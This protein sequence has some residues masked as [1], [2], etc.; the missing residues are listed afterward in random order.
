M[1]NQT[2]EYMR[3]CCNFNPSWMD[4]KLDL[5]KH[6]PEWADEVP[7]QIK[8]MAVKEA[9][10]AFWKAKGRPQWRSLKEPEQTCYIIKSA[11]KPSKGIYPQKSGK[12]LK[13]N[14]S[15]PDNIK[16]GRLIWRFAKWWLA[17]PYKQKLRVAENQGRV[18][19]IDPGVRSFITFYN[20]KVAGHLGKGDFGRIQR[21]CVHMDQLISKRDKCSNKQRKRSMARAL[22]RMRGKLSHLIN[23]LHHKAAK[24]LTDNFD[25]ILL[26]TFETQSMSQRAGRKIS[27]KTVR[28]MLTF[29]HYRFK[30]FLKWKAHCTGKMVVDCS[31]AYTSKTHPETG[32]VRNI[33]GAS[34]IKLRDG[35]I[36]DRDI[37]GAR[38][39]MLRA[40]VDSPMGLEFCTAPCS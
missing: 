3:T 4:I 21:L 25:V 40:L 36:A 14:E 39:I 30:Q 31:E 12:G 38:N 29:A 11:V 7:Y 16:D 9:H 6:L 26:P 19:S 34:E 32:V 27:S 22:K 8:G 18:V 37:V 5:L 35:S 2:I 23:E 20:E 28:N 24:F 13:F 1:F 15:L 17:V 10:E 33:G